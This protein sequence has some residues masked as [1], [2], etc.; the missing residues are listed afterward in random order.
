ML[1]KEAALSADSVKSWTGDFDV[2]QILCGRDGPK[3][4]VS[5]SPRGSF[6]VDIINL[7]DFHELEIDDLEPFH[8]GHSLFPALFSVRSQPIQSMIWDGDETIRFIR[9]GSHSSTRAT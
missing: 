4:E 9:H 7:E 6:I 5:C 1:A 3:A 8:I 2:M